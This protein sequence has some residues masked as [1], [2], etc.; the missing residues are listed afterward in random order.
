VYQI[1]T[2]GRF[3][4]DFETEEFESIPLPDQVPSPTKNLDFLET[5][6]STIESNELHSA[7]TKS[8][9]VQTLLNQNQDL[10]SRLTVALKK[11]IELEQRLEENEDHLRLIKNKLETTSEQNILLK[12]K[13]NHFE[14]QISQLR[15]E[16]QKQDAKFAELYNAYQEKIGYIQKLSYRLH[17]FL[18]YRTRIRGYIRPLINRLKIQT[19]EFKN[20]YI[21]ATEKINEQEKQIQSLKIKVQEALDH[22]QK[23][24]QTFEEDQAELVRYHESRYQNVVSQN[25]NLT[26]QIEESRKA[27]EATKKELERYKENEAELS[28]KSIY[29]ERVYTDLKAEYDSLKIKYTEES[30]RDSQRIKVLESHTLQLSEKLNET[31]QYAQNLYNDHTALND[32]YSSLQILLQENLNKI[33]DYKKRLGSLEQMNRELSQSLLEYRKKNDALEEKL[34]K[35]EDD[36]K[37][38]L[39]SFQH[40][41][42]KPSDLARAIPGVGQKELLNK[43]QNLL[44]EIQTGKNESPSHNSL[45]PELISEHGEISQSY[46]SSDPEEI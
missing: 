41:F 34:Q 39:E 12:E 27:L 20:Y 13:S 21:K 38:K 7:P 22:I 29:F 44:S 23:Q 28:N 6:S 18:K 17:R 8:R 1:D 37:R 3:F 33:E 36:F 31:I 35:T 4:M 14:S 25:E 42:Q 2:G 32:Q 5:R 11:N 19:E 46:K 45:A 40:R 24:T 16:A 26:I 43:I 15:I 10:S 30:L 9:T